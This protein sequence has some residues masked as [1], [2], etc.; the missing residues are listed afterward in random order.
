VNGKGGFIAS[1]LSFYG[2]NAK[3]AQ[4]RAVILDPDQNLPSDKK[5]TTVVTL[6]GQKFTGLLRVRDNFSVS[7]Q[8]LDGTFHFFPK[9]ELAQTDFGS[10]S[11]MPAASSLSGKEVDN[12]VSYLLRTGNEN[13][14]HT[15]AAKSDDADN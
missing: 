10:R 8:T 7:I 13:S 12:L 9:S 3:P 15:P 2:A 1:D 11:L 4:M 14:K 6:S 5:A